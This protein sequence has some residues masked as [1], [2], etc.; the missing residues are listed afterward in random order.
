MYK[1]VDNGDTSPYMT[2]PL[3]ISAL[4]CGLLKR[5]FYV[6]GNDCRGQF[7]DSN[8]EMKI[9][10]HTG[11]LHN[12]MSFKVKGQTKDVNTLKQFGIF[13]SHVGT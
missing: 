6:L 7:M 13:Y 1:E 3:I 11:Y 2:H 12:P 4:L 5:I 8:P 10:G 9:N